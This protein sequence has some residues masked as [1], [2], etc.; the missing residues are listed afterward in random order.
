MSSPRSANIAQRPYGQTLS[1]QPVSQFT[2]TNGH[3][4]RAEII[5]YGGTMTRLLVPDRAG[6]FEDIVL[7]HR[8]LD[9]YRA[10]SAYFGAL[11][12][13]V[14]NRIAA[15]RF[16]L[17]GTAYQLATNDAPGGR[18]CHL[19]GGP[20]G[21]DKVLWQAEPLGAGAALRL[22]YRSPDGEEGYP[23]N[24]DVTV[25]Y[26]LNDDDELIIE[27][28]AA[29][30][31]PTP[32]NLTQHNYYNLRG[33]SAGDI[34]GHLLTLHA[35]RFT[36]VDAGLIPT[37]AFKEVAGTPFDFTRPTRIGDRIEATDE[38]LRFGGGYDHNWVIDRAG[39]GLAHAAS[40]EAPES[41]R[42]MD[43]WTDA[44]GIQFYAGNAIPPGSIGKT[45]RP[46]APRQGFCLETQNH[47]DAPNHPDFPPAILRPGADYRTTTVYR[48]STC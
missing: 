16:T 17:D 33:E 22:R 36:P 1:G 40:V 11:I 13:R 7:G 37:G 5:T 31:R 8:S 19:H 29:C 28:G 12:G 15:G 47:P 45:G 46:Y 43:V 10:G 24:L 3:G 41:G 35:G 25:T 9:E 30:D 32:V 23:G 20:R 27:Y 2:L 48:F 42:R 14:G 38:Q 26:R 4:L 18:P 21:F 44:P 34:L 6:R 39:P